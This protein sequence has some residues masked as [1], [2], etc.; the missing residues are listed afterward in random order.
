MM[1]R[2]HALLLAAL[3]GGLLLSGCTAKNPDPNHT[4]ADFAVWVGGT[5]LDFSGE[6]Y[7][8]EEG[9]DHDEYFHLHDGNGRVIHRHKPG[10]PLSEF[11]ESLGLHIADGCLTLDATQYAKLDPSFRRDF[12]IQPRLC[13]NGK[14]H[15]TMYVNGKKRPVD[16]GYVFEDGDQILFAYDAGDDHTQLL[17]RLTNDA[18]LYSQTCPLRGKPPTEHCIADPA[19]PCV[20][21]E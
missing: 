3:F 16:F 17:K 13:P 19:V 6:Q 10:L 4:H 1:K 8:S 5:K 11:F 9:A 12:N 7:M 21:S 2:T 15:W 14:F 18:C 20:E